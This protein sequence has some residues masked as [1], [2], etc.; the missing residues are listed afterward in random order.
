MAAISYLL[1]TFFL[2]FAVLRSCSMDKEVGPSDLFLA[3]G[4]GLGLSSLV[5]FFTVLVCGKYSPIPVI[6]AGV[7]LSLLAWLIPSVKRKTINMKFGSAVPLYCFLLILVP[8]L[9]VQWYVYAQ[10]PWGDWDA[11]SFW[12]TRANAIFRGDDNW[13]AIFHLIFQARHPWL[14]PFSIVWGWTFTAQETVLVPALVATLFSVCIIG[15]CVYGLAPQIGRFGA[16]LS[17]IYL[18]SIPFFARHSGSQYADVVAAFY[19]LGSVFVLEKASQEKSVKY[20]LLSGLLLGCLVN[21]KDE[22]IVLCIV[23][24]LLSYFHLDRK[25]LISWK[26]LLLAAAPFLGMLTWS[27]LM[28]RTMLLPAPFVGGDSQA[29]VNLMGVFDWHRWAIIL[30]HFFLV[31]ALHPLSGG[32]WLLF[33]FLLLRR[34]SLHSAFVL[35]FMLSFCVFFCSLYLISTGNLKWRLMVSMDRLFFMLMPLMVWA[36]FRELFSGQ[37]EGHR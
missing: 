19:L 33:A 34:R 17:G 23:L 7:G 12:N 9:I 4:T 1:L 24:L 37:G 8:L 11:W 5:T 15:L 35:K 32:V 16:L 20:S 26:L 28:M 2:G 30:E 25:R 27:E 18:V 10:R 29:S 21:S 31:I 13:S 36:A 22:G 3:L 6:S 14:L